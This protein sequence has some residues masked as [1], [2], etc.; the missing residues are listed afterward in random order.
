MNGSSRIAILGALLLAAC[1]STPEPEP[2]DVGG[3]VVSPYEKGRLYGGKAVY[4]VYAPPSVVEDVIL[5]FESQHEFRPMVLEAH[6]ISKTEEGGQVMFRFRGAAGVHPQANCVYKIEREDGRFK[7]TYEMT[8]PS[9]ALWA[10]N[11]AFA[12]RPVE[13][14]TKTW[15]EQE[16]LVSAL[17]ANKQ[18]LLAELKTDAEAIKARAEQVAAG[19]TAGEK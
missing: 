19:G 2:V 13:G 8:D 18:S 9:F 1:A 15:V 16:F 17:V 14:G 7:L 4:T 6:L 12:L 3:V 11:G 10:L 5:D